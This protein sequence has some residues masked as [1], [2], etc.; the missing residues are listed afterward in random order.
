MFLTSRILRIFSVLFACAITSTPVAYAKDIRWKPELATIGDYVTI[1]QSQ[2]GRIHHVFKG[3]SGRAF[4][5]ESFRGRSPQGVSVFT[6]YLDKNGNYLRWVRA[7]GFEIRFKPHDCTRTI[8]RCKY[9]EIH[10]DGKR[11]NRTRVTKVTRTGFSFQEYDHEGKFLFGGRI[12][13]DERGNAGNGTI[14]GYQGKQ[15]FRLIK[16]IYQ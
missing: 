12:T 9:T 13:L 16:R 1:D 6:T 15:R 2:G 7:D 4:I 10:S 8:G 3:K 11:N 5:I 14:Q